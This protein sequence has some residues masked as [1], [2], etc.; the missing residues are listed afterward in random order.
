M[1]NLVQLVAGV[2]YQDVENGSFAK[3]TI[4]LFQG[5]DDSALQLG[6]WSVVNHQLVLRSSPANQDDAKLAENE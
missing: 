5:Y 3:P 6:Q 2:G 4:V 1:V